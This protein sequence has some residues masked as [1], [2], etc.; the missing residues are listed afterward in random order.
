MDSAIYEQELE[1]LL[2]DLALKNRE[3][4]NAE[5]EVPQP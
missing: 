1:R 3:I 2:I 5:D 4:R